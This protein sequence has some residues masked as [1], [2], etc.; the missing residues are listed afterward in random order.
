[1]S[2]REAPQIVHQDANQLIATWK[3]VIV[4]QFGN[5]PLSEDAARRQVAISTTQ[6]QR[7]GPSQLL[8]I[9]LIDRETPLPTPG[10]RAVLDLAVRSVGPYYLGVASVFEGTG[11][12]AALVRGVLTLLAMLARTLFPQRVF[13]SDDECTTWCQGRLGATPADASDLRAI[14]AMVRRTAVEQDIVTY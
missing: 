7:F 5:S 10:A 12:R 1:M 6:G 13:A 11:F 14:I 3:N 9:A 4:C 8:E 2:V